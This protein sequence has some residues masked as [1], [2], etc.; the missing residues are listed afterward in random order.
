MFST[1]FS[2][3]SA[4]EA[5]LIRLASS[6]FSQEG[7]QPQSIH[8]KNNFNEH[9]PYQFTRFVVPIFQ[10]CWT[11]K[12]ELPI[13]INRANHISGILNNCAEFPKNFALP[14][15]VVSF[16]NL[17]GKTYV[18][19]TQRAFSLSY[20]FTL[21]TTSRTHGSSAPCAQSSK[22]KIRGIFVAGST[23]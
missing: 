19:P 3:Y 15:S 16:N 21:N 8:G 18:I 17:A 1:I 6:N 23:F 10:T 13:P 2:N 7:A 14:L 5:T 12:L 11:D 4:F 20:S 9:P 22:S